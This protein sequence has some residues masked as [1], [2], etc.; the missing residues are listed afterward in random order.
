MTCRH[1]KNRRTP[2]SKLIAVQ[3]ALGANYLN[4]LELKFADIRFIVG[5]KPANHKELFNLV[6]T[7][8]CQE[9]QH[10]TSDG[11]T[12]RYRYIND[13]PLNRNACFNINFLNIGK[14]IKMA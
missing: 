9:Y 3:D 7:N 10:E 13:V 14:Q 12:H 11:K 8:T 5:V 1:D 2:Q 6:N 4:L